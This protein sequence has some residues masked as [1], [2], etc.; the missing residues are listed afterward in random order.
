MNCK[1][2]RTQVNAEKEPNLMQS[3]VPPTINLAQFA[4]EQKKLS[5][6][7]KIRNGVN[8]FIWIAGL[9]ILNSII[10]LSGSTLTFVIGLGSTQFVDGFMS[11]LAK[12]LSQSTLNFKGIGFLIDLCIAGVFVILGILGRKLKRWPII[13]GIVFYTIDAIILLLFQDMIGVLF[14]GWALFGIIRGLMSFK[15]L[16]NLEKSGVNVPV[17]N[18]SQPLSADQLPPAAPE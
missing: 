7:N 17:E 13:T 18:L 11:A 2:R 15:D 10:Y 5:L 9:S 1:D 16:H 14:H 12:D 4:I 3:N 6:A 8:W